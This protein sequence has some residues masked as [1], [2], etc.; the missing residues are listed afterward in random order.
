MLEKLVIKN[1]ALIDSVEIDFGKGLNV[2][3]GE[4]GSGKSVIIEAL[5]FVL[6]A[7]AE[8]SLIKSGQNE[9]SVL[10]TFSVDVNNLTDVFDSLGVEP[11]ETVIISRKF[12][13]DGKSI[14]RV[15]GTTINVSMLKKLSAILVDVHGQSEHFELLSTS[16]QL[17]LL[18]KICYNDIKDVKN[19]LKDLYSEYKGI[20]SQINTLGG[21][22]SQRLIRLDVLNYQINEIVRADIKPNEEKELIELR[23]KLQNQEKISNALNGA[24]SAFSDDGGILDVLGNVNRL[25]LSISNLTEEF[26]SL[27]DRISTL[28]SECDDFASTICDANSNNEDFINVNPDDVEARLSIIK[29]IKRKYGE[30]Y[31]DIL[32]FLENAKIEKD[33]LDNF[34]ELYAELLSKKSKIEK[35]LYNN[36]CVLSKTRKN[37]AINFSKSVLSELRELG[38][39]KAEFDI[40]FNDTPNIEDCKFDSANGFDNVQ[41][42]FSANPGE[43]LKPM[44]KIISGG[45]MSRFMLSIKAQ[46][47]KFNEQ[48]TF[49]FDEIDAGIS[50]RVAKTVANKFAK[51]SANTQL[52]AITHLPQISSMADVNLL[53]E[54]NST[55]DSAITTV[56]RLTSI[57]KVEEIVR[58]I[59][60]EIN[61]ES[62]IK[63]ATEMIDNA[64]EYKKSLN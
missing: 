43:P 30:S 21:D 45:E 61:S 60:G 52:I 31:E 57:Q 47:S 39:D 34:N 58:L 22:E 46:S 44:D 64:N 17:K 10:A 50:G 33:K 19:T 13:L 2:L 11:D 55:G 5:N 29:N 7:K 24:Y 59:G 20:N 56:K 16:N 1:V 35:E 25:I 49:I 36:Y 18:D 27:S 41:F 28:Y 9:C 15:N 42:L 14:V 8:K 26:S 37:S 62:A 12:N 32:A 23:S 4:T 51:I 3:S 38:M 48:K 6:G 63:H 40:L 54:K 53:I